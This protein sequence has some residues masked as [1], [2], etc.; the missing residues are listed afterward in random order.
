MSNIKTTSDGFSF[1]TSE[2][3][4]Y[5][6]G[7]RFHKTLKL[8]YEAAQKSTHSCM[9][10]YPLKKYESKTIKP[11]CSTM[12]R[13]HGIVLFLTEIVKNGWHKYTI[14]AVVNPR[15]VLEPESGYL[16]IAPTDEDS[17]ERFQD[18]F[19]ALMRRYDLPEFLDE[20]TLTRLDLCVN[21]QLNKKKSAR[22][23]C[24]LLQKDLLPPK[25]ER[26]YFYDPRANEEVREK[27]K[28]ADQHSI[29]L[30]NKSYG[31]VVYD[32]LYQTEAESL[33]DPSDWK[34]LPDGIL[35]LELRCFKPYL[36]KLAAK[37]KLD[38]TSE[39]LYWMAQHSRELIL[40]R[41]CQVFSSGTHYKPEAAKALINQSDFHK[42]TKK[43]L[44]WLF[45]RMRYPFSLE[46]LE[47]GMEKQFELKP[48]TVVKRLD[49]LQEL[50]INLIPLRKDFYLEQLPS[51][52]E[53]LEL[54]E[55][56][57]SSF[58]LTSNGE[59]EW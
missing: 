14:K 30:A 52:P 31:F 49:Q 55:D 26:V 43:Q 58:K 42:D 23:F 13:H 47:K 20:W 41:V 9:T 8:L 22:E 48:R 5:P 54:L 53:I 12:L 4:S 21:L 56:G 6:D 7:K 2:L 3:K 46:Q 40:K 34:K 39:Q 11:H 1:H 45:K 50:G 10:T 38:S 18:E 44:W 19:T 51:L 24:R 29:C 35:R 28:Q 59:I 27:Q 33:L 37:E 32:K 57:S 17:L 15:R 16:G 25:M 36:D